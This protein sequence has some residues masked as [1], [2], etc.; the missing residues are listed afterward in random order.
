[1]LLTALGPT[2]ARAFLAVKRSEWEAFSRENAAYET[3]HHFW[4][5]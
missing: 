5:F 4:K 2:L 3:K 1:V